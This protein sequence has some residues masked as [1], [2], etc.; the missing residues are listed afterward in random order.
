MSRIGIPPQAVQVM[1]EALDREWINL[2]TEDRDAAMV[3]ILKAAAPHLDTRPNRRPRITCPVCRREVVKR[4]DGKPTTHYAVNHDPKFTCDGTM[5]SR[6]R[7]G[8]KCR[9]HR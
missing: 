3:R 8:C 5:Y 9:K 2:Q 6:C 4:D 1:S 7:G